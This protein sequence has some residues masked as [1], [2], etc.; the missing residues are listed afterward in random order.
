MIF[1]LC[2]PLSAGEHSVPDEDGES[3][4]DHRLRSGPKVR[5]DEEAAG[6]VRDA[7]IRRA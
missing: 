6:A 7:G 3:D 1:F 4:Q 5:A 2:V